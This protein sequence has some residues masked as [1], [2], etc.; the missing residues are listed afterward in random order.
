MG[1]PDPS[2]EPG[3]RGLLGNAQRELLEQLGIDGGNQDW[4]MV[5]LDEATRISRAGRFILPVYATWEQIEREEEKD[6]R[7]RNRIA[8]ALGLEEGASWLDLHDQLKTADEATRERFK[9][10]MDDNGHHI[11][12]QRSMRIAR[13]GVWEDSD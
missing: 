3:T 12:Y 2:V 4:M 11:T 8:R 9:K 5:L 10:T 6:E 13:T 1:L 7:R